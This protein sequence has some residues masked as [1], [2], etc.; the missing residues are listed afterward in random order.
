MA[1]ARRGRPAVLLCL[2]LT[3]APALAATQR[4][5]DIAAG[6]L[7]PAITALAAQ[8]GIDIGAIDP[9]LAKARTRGV[10]GRFEPG[11]ALDRLLAGSGYRAERIDGSAY[12]IVRTAKAT[13]AAP[14]RRADPLAERRTGGGGDIIVTASKRQAPLLRFPGSVTILQAPGSERF[15]VG[16]MRDFHAVSAALPILQSTDLGAGRNKLFIRGIADSSFAGP[17]RSTAS[18]YFGDVQLGYNGADPN[19]NLYDIASIEILEGPQGALYGAGSIGGI[20]R[21]TPN[22]PDSK[23][24]SASASA[25]LG[26]TQH[27]DTSHGL[28][29]MINMPLRDNVAALRAIAY[30]SHDGGYVDDRRRGASDINR[31]TT[32]GGRASLRLTPDER[33]TIDL[34]VV[35]QRIASADTQYATADVGRLARESAIAQPFEG[36]FVLVRG[37][38]GRVWDDGLQLL[39]AA[40]WAVHQ[41][42]ARFDATL[43]SRPGVPLA[44]DTHEHNQLTTI[45][46]RLSRSTPRGNS[47]LLGMSYIRDRD[48]IRRELGPPDR[49]RDITGVTNVATDLSMF[50]EATFAVTTGLSLTG[51]GRLTFTRTDGNPVYARSAP[52]HI[53][54][55]R[56]ARLSPMLAANL[57][58]APRLAWFARYGSGFRTGG[59]AVAPGVGRVADFTPDTIEVVETGL[60][61][62]RRGPLGLSAS[63]AISHARWSR[64]QADLIDGRGFPN[65]A[66]IGDGRIT[67]LEATIDWIPTTG[68]HLG[69][70]AFLNRSRLANPILRLSRQEGDALPD[71]PRGAASLRASYGWDIGT[72]S[73]LNLAGDMRYT[74]ISY[75][76]FGPM[77]NVR[78]GGYAAFDLLVGW[79]RRGIGISLALD[80]LANVAGNRFAL[81]NPFGVAD[82]NQRTPMRPRTLRLSLSVGA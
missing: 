9:A 47:W 30:R 34:G 57:I 78:Q 48:A 16:G 36:D 25:T 4:A 17:T 44:Y 59:L 14:A 45:E 40:G 75:V 8:G 18:V 68:L 12:R 29:A 24:W 6:P 79:Q 49:Q 43:R 50:G 10:H 38:V 56:S 81:G 53:H 21:L 77:L 82:R 3:A 58:V 80:N 26:A 76:G 31:A 55:H 1:A 11:S 63:A 66:N 69:G 74:G 33:W 2:C 32:I 28:V 67:G 52:A 5:F 60:R 19:L 51:G 7:G 70:A 46:T 42:D 20:I 27:G 72:D 71:T 64:I 61:L 37:V 22:A 13:P 15:G 54:G 41:T 62:T 23:A 35:G 39:A 65:T 73:R